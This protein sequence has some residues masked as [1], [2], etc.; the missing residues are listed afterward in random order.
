[1]MAT[2]PAAASAIARADFPAAV[3]PT[4]TRMTSS[5]RASGATK[6][7]LHLAPGELHDRR[8]AMHVVRREPRVA[9]RDEER[10][11]LV[12]RE[13]VPRLHRGLARHG[14]EHALVS[15]GGGGD[16]IAGEG[17]E[18]LAEATL[19]VEATMRRGDGVDRD[20]VAAEGRDLVAHALEFGAMP[21]E[22]VQLRGGEIEREW[23]QQSLRRRVAALELA[24]ERLVQHALVRGMLVDED[25]AVL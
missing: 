21:L 19:R 7:A 24:Q 6:A 25:D 12:G 5:R 14:R 2:S 1:M 8:A 18:R 16:A 20:G 10:A 13:R 23:Q 17:R 3:G 11:H 22:R 4:M 15:R 9:Q